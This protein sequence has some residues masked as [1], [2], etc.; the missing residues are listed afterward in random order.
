MK[1]KFTLVLVSLVFVTG[2]AFSA[3][4]EM[5]QDLMQNIE[6][7]TKS[8]TSNIAMKDIKTAVS[9]VQELEEM[10]TKVEDFYKSQADK[11][12]AVQMTAKS[13]Q[14]IVGLR[15]D[16]HSK[17]FDHANELA[18]SLTRLCK[19]CHNVFKKDA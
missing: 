8:L 5:D 14:L 13:L 12:E 11:E 6:D 3:Q 2:V 7:T 4:I 15:K 1:N 18:T 16:L 9:E 19:T 10:F 17:N